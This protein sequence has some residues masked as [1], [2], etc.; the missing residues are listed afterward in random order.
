MVGFACA[1]LQKEGKRKGRKIAREREKRRREGRERRER[2]PQYDLKTQVVLKS[3]A[4]WSMRTDFLAVS[5]ILAIHD[6]T[7]H[8]TSPYHCTLTYYFSLNDPVYLLKG[9]ISHE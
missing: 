9:K 3:P 5:Q 4:S 2:E 6:S 8:F 1:I 7:D